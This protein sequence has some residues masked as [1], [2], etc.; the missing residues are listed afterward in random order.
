MQTVTDR[1]RVIAFFSAA[2][3]K[4]GVKLGHSVDTHNG[5]M[6]MGEINNA[7]FKEHC[8]GVNVADYIAMGQRLF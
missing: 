2:C 8:T 6:K 1:Y 4:F 3:R 7:F 5:S